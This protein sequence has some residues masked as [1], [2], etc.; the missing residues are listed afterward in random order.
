MMVQAESFND[1]L[2]PCFEN[3]IQGRVNLAYATNFF[4]FV[5]DYPIQGEKVFIGTLNR[6]VFQG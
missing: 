4:N 3:F 2:S 1:S 5:A 6:V